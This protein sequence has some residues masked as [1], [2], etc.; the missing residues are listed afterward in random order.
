M[1]VKIKICGLSREEDMEYADQIMPDYIGFV[2]WE[3]SRRYVS[4]ERAAALRRLLKPE[5][6][7]VG[8][9]VDAPREEILSL[10][11]EGV[12]DMA[13]LHGGETEE[14]IRYL[15]AAT[16]KPVIKAVKVRNRR[17][18]EAWLDSSADHLLFDSGMG[19]GA[20]FDWG[21]L[22]D[23]PREFFLAGGL[24]P[25]NLRQAVETVRPYA[26]DISSGVETDGVKDRGKMQ[27]AVDLVR[28]IT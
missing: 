6:Q 3:H 16:G 13:Q 4:P 17:D 18:V 19:S 25:E 24:R 9:F 23:I 7:A 5:I 12:I 21:L 26:V 2:F 8:V 20:A 1:T 14:D 10:L 11:R 28:S 27:E 22:K 15:Q